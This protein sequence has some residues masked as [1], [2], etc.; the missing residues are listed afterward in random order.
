M[1]AFR[2]AALPAALVLV[3]QAALA[4]PARERELMEAVAAE[5]Q[6][7][8]HYLELADYYAGKDRVS[9]ADGVLRDALSAIDP[10]SPTVYE[11]RVLLYLDPF[12]P[13]RI[14]AIADEWLAVDATS[15]V[16]VLLSAGHRLRTASRTRGDAT[17][18]SERE[19]DLGLQTIDGA[20]PANPDVA[21][22]RFMR[23]NLLQARAALATDPKEQRE[24]LEEARDAYRRG[25]DLRKA[26]DGGPPVG[27]ALSGVIAAMT[28][29][30]PFGPPGA[31]RAGTIVPYPRLI[32]EGRRRH[33]GPRGPRPGVMLEIVVGPDGRVASVYAPQ[34]LDG[35]DRALAGLVQERE[36]EITTIGGQ[37]VPVIVNVSI[38]VPR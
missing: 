7:I 20:V 12:R 15:A 17:G 37:P 30:P 2:V 35:Y 16:T 5:P 36:Y 26:S 14:G 9:D 22:L 10:L 6:E 11:R 1:T 34:S 19:I 25:E 31:V 29:M 24:W 23:S 32:T 3:S 21:E 38:A 4:Q 18:Q 27:G 13:L 33:A 8:R 28:R